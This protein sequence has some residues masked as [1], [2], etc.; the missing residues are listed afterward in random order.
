MPL[1][2]AG[3][4]VGANLQGPEAIFLVPGGSPEFW[5]WFCPSERIL[6]ILSKFTNFIK[7]DLNW[8]I[9]SQLIKKY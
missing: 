7:P 5:N 9:T 3:G 2:L 8:K 6:Q 4:T 1:G